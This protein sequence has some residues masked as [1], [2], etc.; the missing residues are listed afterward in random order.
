MTSDPEDEVRT[1][2]EILKALGLRKSGVQFISCPTCGRCKI[3]LIEIAN[4]V[5]DGL[6]DV[7]KDIKLAIMGCAVN[8]PG[9]AKEADIGI[10]CGDGEALLFKKGKIIRKIP[11][12]RI[13]EELLR[14]IKE[15]VK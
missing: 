11:G 9:E 6:K 2:I 15:G 1:G 4:K 14:E 13:V 3:N 10:A 8:G 7:D 5:Q 12:D